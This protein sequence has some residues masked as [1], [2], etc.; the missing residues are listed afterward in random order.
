[1]KTSKK[2]IYPHLRSRKKRDSKKIYDFV[3][4]GSGIGGVYTA[5]KLSQQYPNKSILLIEKTNRLGG[6]IHSIQIS[7]KNDPNYILEAGA[8]R[9]SSRHSYL[10]TLIKELNLEENIRPSS[11]K[12]DYLPVKT[13]SKIE[14][15]ENLYSQDFMQP[16]YDI[17]PI[18]Q[19]AIS[20]EVGESKL[21]QIVAKVILASKLESRE[22]LQDRHFINYAENIISKEEIQHIY[23]SFGYYSELV[24]MNAYDSIELMQ[25]LGPNNS[26]YVL[27]GG[28][29]QIIDR[30]VSSF[31]RKVEI[32]LNETV[33]NISKKEKS[34]ANYKIK[35]NKY[36]FLADT[37]ICALPKPN[38]SKL[39]IFRPILSTLNKVNCGILC[40]IYAKFHPSEKDWY[41]PLEKFTTNNHI[42]M[43]IPM[44]KET[45]IVMI[46]YSDNKYAEYWNALKTKQKIIRQWKKEI[47][48][49]TGIR[50]PDPIDIYVYYWPCGVGYWAIGANSTEISQ[51][52]IQPMPEKYPNLFCCGENYSEKHQQWIEGAL[53]TSEKVILNI[54]EKNALFK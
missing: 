12:A 34:S 20:Y 29:S 42:R 40:R 27:K 26:F 11:G 52:M 16:I 25:Q 32:R 49:S 13:D 22:Y 37:V 4:L 9:F 43:F 18:L 21:S 36:T 2:K 38:L 47:Y 30:M 48:E 50:A 41:K 46:S 31:S 28:L 35:T 44:N 23:D 14:K 15:K 8:G 5:Y 7:P 19:L 33:T 6:R 45:G 1:M 51:K 39:S 10:Q 24:M 54:Y 17:K 3:I 53:E